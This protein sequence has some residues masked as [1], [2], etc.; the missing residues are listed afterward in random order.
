MTKHGFGHPSGRLVSGKRTLSLAEPIVVAASD[1]NAG[2][3]DD[4]AVSFSHSPRKD[5][6]DPP[7]LG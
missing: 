7:D 6:H 3:R 2:Y 4:A 5:N 1:D